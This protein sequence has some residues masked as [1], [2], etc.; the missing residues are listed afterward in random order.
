MNAET[1]AAL[2]DHRCAATVAGDVEA[3]AEI[4]ADDLRYTHSHGGMDTKESMISN[5]A[6]GVFI[7]RGIHR[8]D[9]V[10]TLFDSTAI[11]TGRARLELTAAGTDRTVH[12]RYTDVWAEVDGRWQF[13]AWQS[14]PVAA[15]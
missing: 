4:Y 7:Y 14:T 3:L 1:I 13:V 5:I 11:V 2:E 12:C 10:V 15:E 9:V 6:N 8:S